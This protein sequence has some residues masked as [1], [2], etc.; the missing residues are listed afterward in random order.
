LAAKEKLTS[1]FVATQIYMEIQ[2]RPQIAKISLQ[3]KINVE[4]ENQL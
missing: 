1:W 3:K 2:K 4:K